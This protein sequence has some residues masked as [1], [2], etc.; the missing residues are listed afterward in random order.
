M[1]APLSRHHYS[2]LVAGL[3]E[4]D[5]DRD[6]VAQFLAWYAEAA[7]EA[8][9]L[10]TASV[11]GVPSVRMV[12]LKGVDQRGFAFYTNYDSAKARDLAVNPRAA[13]CFF[14]PPDRQ[15][16]VSGP[17]ETIEAGES[18]RYWRNRPR[19]SQL[20]A[21]ASRQSQVVESR[22]A[23]EQRV[24]ELAARFG[25]GE[26]PLPPFWGGFRLVP[27]VVEFWHHR[28]DRLHDRIRYRRED[29]N[30]VMERLAP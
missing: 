28:E 20:S 16:R 26:V 3:H 10:A 29:G 17:V 8:V 6:P 30:W 7:T 25:E 19:A 4:D 15:V 24:V 5:V 27:A 12:L 18:E 14:W 23:L 1:T 21:W 11:D 9:A 13:L 22:E 2:R